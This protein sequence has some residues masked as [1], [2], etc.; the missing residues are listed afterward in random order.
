MSPVIEYKN[1]ILARI[2]VAARTALSTPSKVELISLIGA[3]PSIRS[4][5]RLALAAAFLVATPI[6]FVGVMRTEDVARHAAT[7]SDF[8]DYWKRLLE[9]RIALKELDLAI[10]AY[11]SEPEFENGQAVLVA[12][13]YFKTAIEQMVEHRPTNFEIGPSGFFEGLA[14]RLDGL[15]KRSIVNR[16]SMAQA[17][18]SIM[19]MAKELK[20]VEKRV[21]DIARYERREALGSLSMVGRDQLILFLVLLFAIPIFVGFVPGWL[22]SPLARLRQIARKI[23]TGRIKDIQVNG[24]DEVAHLARTLR[25]YLLRKDE[26]DHKKSSKIFEMR[27]VLRAA[28]SR[29]AEPVFIIDSGTK[30]NYTNEA[31]A[32]L[33]GLPQHQIEGKPLS[34]CLYSQTIKKVCE[35]AFDGEISDLAVDAAIEVPDGRTFSKHAKIGVVRN[36]DGD[37]SRVVVVLNASVPETKAFDDAEEGS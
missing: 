15:I 25:S 5:A 36:R 18:L 31:A 1:R 29:V 8:D 34:D 17:R 30:I 6:L 14:S 35:R 7:L 24:R 13:E 19:S 2:S 28:V 22:V 23:E 12:S 37:I 27:N 21:I 26:L 9:T 4:R 11:S 33:I 20:S 32:Q 16:G 3:G 10:W